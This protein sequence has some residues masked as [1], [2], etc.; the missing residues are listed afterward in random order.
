MAGTRKMKFPSM[1]PII[2]QIR[3]GK[4]LPIDLILLHFRKQGPAR[5]SIGAVPVW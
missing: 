5:R 3:V 4:D 2:I 1:T